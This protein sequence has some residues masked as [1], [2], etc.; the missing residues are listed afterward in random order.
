MIKKLAVVITILLCLCLCACNISPD[1]SRKDEET[2]SSEITTDH[3]TEDVTTE[4]ITT[5]GI[6]IE[7]AT[8]ENIPLEFA[9]EKFSFGTGTY[10]NYTITPENSDEVLDWLNKTF[11]IGGYDYLNFQF[12]HDGSLSE[13]DFY[14]MNYMEIKVHKYLPRPTISLKMNFENINLEALKKLSHIPAISNIFI[15]HPSYYT[16]IDQ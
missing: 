8:T 15:Y 12:E 11:D 13:N 6:T 9:Y 4:D 7:N 1:A 16:V 10:Y 2:N 3:T 14:E 5:E